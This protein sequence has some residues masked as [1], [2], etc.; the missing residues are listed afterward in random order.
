V[1]KTNKQ[2]VR[3]LNN[4]KPKVPEFGKNHLPAEMASKLLCDPEICA[5]NC[6]KAEFGAPLDPQVQEFLQILA[7]ECAETI[8]RITKILRFG[9]R[10]NPWDGKDNVER[11]ESEIGDIL[12]SL[13]VLASLKVIDPKRIEAHEL[14]KLAAFITEENPAKPRLRHMD[15][16][17]R[18]TLAKYHAFIKE[19]M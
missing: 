3:D 19:S 4:L 5:P 12:A 1:T 18:A 16:A 8:Q 7:E 11:F 17:L 6:P 15:D 13:D 2:G 14:K 10:R 9:L